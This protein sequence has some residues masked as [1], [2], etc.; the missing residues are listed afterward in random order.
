ML[1]ERS[2]DIARANAILNDPDVLPF[3]SE[4]SGAIDIAKQIENPANVLYLGEYG[5]TLYLNLMPGT[6]EVHSAALKKGRGSWMLAFAQR[7]LDAIFVQTPAW[8]VLTRV[9]HGNVAALALTKACGFV[10][11]FDAMNEC[12]Y[13]GAKVTPG[14]WRLSIHDWVKRSS[15]FEDMGDWFHSRLGQEAHRLGIAEQAHPEN[16]HHNRIA[17][18]SLAMARAGQ[19]LK[20]TYFYDRWSAL[21]RHSMISL[22]CADPPTFK[23]DIGVLRLRGDDIEVTRE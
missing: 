1:I 4:K 12:L 3:V 7:S 11:E 8:E 18:A 2:T 9:P 10:H 17:G 22:I 15:F 20:A 14:I 5:L 21:S 23:M 19:A 6:Y 13:N 16:E